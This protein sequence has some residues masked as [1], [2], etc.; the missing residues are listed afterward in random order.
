MLIL[1]QLIHQY[2]FMFIVCKF[3][4][5][6]IVLLLLIAE[7]KYKI[8]FNLYANFTYVQIWPWERVLKF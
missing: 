6:A 1:E 3:A 2:K 4:E 7:T 5:Y 8:H